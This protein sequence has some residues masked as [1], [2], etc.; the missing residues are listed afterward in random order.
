MSDLVKQLRDIIAQSKPAKE[1]FWYWVGAAAILG[2]V[3][4][5]YDNAGTFT[6]PSLLIAALCA[7]LNYITSKSRYEDA[8]QVKAQAEKD[9]K[10]VTE[11]TPGNTNF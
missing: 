9:I 5:W 11:P 6:I 2:G 10:A 3:A 8:K 4:Y 1:T 7:G